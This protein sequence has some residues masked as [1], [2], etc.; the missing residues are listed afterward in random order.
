MSSEPVALAPTASTANR[1]RAWARDHAWTLVVVGGMGAWLAVVLDHVWTKHA[2][3]ATAR[4][5]LG[6]M[7]QAV[8][9]T[10]HGRPLE[11]TTGAGEQMVRLGS[12]VDPILALLAPA[13]LVAP[14]PLMLAVVQVAAVAAGALPVYWLGRR[15]LGTDR[16]AA[17]VALA[18]LVY[19]WT[20]WVAVDAMHPVTLAVP[21]V[22]FAIWFL[23]GDRL[24][25]FA[26]VAALALMCGELVGLTIA[27][28]GLWYAL[29]RGRRKAGLAIAALAAGWT[30]VAI[31]VVIPAF[32][33]DESPY[34]SYFEAV[35]GS[36]EGLVRTVFTDPGAVLTAITGGRDLLYPILL[37]VPLV[38]AFLLAP[39]LAA[40]ALPQI[41]VN[42]LAD[43]PMT[44]DPRHHYVSLV[45]PVLIA[46][47]VVGLGRIR[48][49]KRL[50]AATV[51][52]A[53]AGT[54]VVLAG[55][56][57]GAG[58]QPVGHRVSYP[59]EHLR[60]LRDA[61]ALVPD[62]VPVTSTNLVGGHLSERR[63]V[64]SVPVVE[65]A[66][67]A[68]VDTWNA[69]IP[70]FERLEELR[71]DVV[72]AMMD[73]LEASGEWTKVFDRSGVVVYRK[74]SR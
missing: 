4:Y 17:L 49:A 3:V 46:A 41:L 34:Y 55:P 59:P 19:P 26:L 31:K 28:L 20:V 18:Y 70:S 10:A 16:A 58:F 15:H 57:P 66:E 14:S 69:W 24:V 62:G 33:G 64:Y 53:V 65:D 13:W 54:S 40:V 2:E 68:V 72:Q 52:L 11:A 12:H 48:A 50:R 9:S 7:T 42:V 23:D 60:A 1:L 51:V 32:A 63:Y 6:N 30:L 45:V 74:G 21:L 25:P 35:G 47:T 67:W 39:A 38:G 73:R 29:A 8:W 56:I 61:I 71:P 37:A 44:T 22:L 27:A 43:R 36:P 5:D